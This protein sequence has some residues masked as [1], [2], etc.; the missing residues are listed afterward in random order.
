MTRVRFDRLF[1]YSM[2]AAFML[3]VL[4]THAFAADEEGTFKLTSKAVETEISK[5]LKVMG[6]GDAIQATITGYVSAVLA[7]DN[8]PMEVNISGLDYDANARSWTAKMRVKA[9]GKLIQQADLT[10]RFQRLVDVPVLTRR[11]H[12]DDVISKADITYKQMP[13]NRLRS[14]TVFDVKALIGQSPR[15]VISHE[16]P[17]RVHEI[18]RPTVVERG[19]LLQ[20]HFTNG[21]LHISTLAEAR[22]DGAVG[23][24]IRVQNV[25]SHAVMQARLLSDGNAEVISYSQI[26]DNRF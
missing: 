15:R 17:I 22:Q 4:H 16:R 14:D 5:Q 9:G 12:S 11:L 26:S 6:A 7:S 20:V 10:G 2:I 18:E 21:A 3:A 13:E 8:A 1:I 23:D 24:I 25:D 19:G